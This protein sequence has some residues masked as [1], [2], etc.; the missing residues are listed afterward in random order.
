MDSLSQAVLGAS[1]VAAAVPAHQRRVALLAGAALGTLPDLDTL[2][3]PLFT[4]TPVNL[5]TWHRGPSHAL[6]LLVLL[7]LCIWWLAC[8]F[9]PR[10][11][12]AP[13][14]WLIGIQ[15]ALLTHPLL[16]A[17]TVYGTQLWWPAPLNPT[18]WSTLFIID[19]LY[20][21]P[22]LLG[23]VL[24]FA[25]GRAAAPARYASVALWLGLGLSTAYVGWSFAARHLVTL[26]LER[27]M[28][29]HGLQG[30]PLLVTPTAINTLVWRGVV[31]TP[32][33]YAVAY[34]SVFDGASASPFTHYPS[35]VPLLEQL[36]A[37]SLEIQRLQWFTS[38]FV[39][40]RKKGD[41]LLLDDLRMG[42]ERNGYAFTFAIA[43]Q[44]PTG[45]QPLAPVQGYPTQIHAAAQLRQAWQRLQNPLP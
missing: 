12:Q 27:S 24:A 13:R 4:Q 35:E 2:V 7:G 28:A 22:L 20:T 33:G 32:D 17:L 21:V 18:M 30:R 25:G 16:D 39:A 11:R 29:A 42:D 8:R 3:L 43:R 15:L 34:R 5:F 38:G 14:G 40:A 26:G 41:L 19:P 9:S 10:V 23:V 31:R 44:S 37:Q 45:W 36:A 1:V 6:W